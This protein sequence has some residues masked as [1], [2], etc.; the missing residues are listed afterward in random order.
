MIT[1]GEA[2]MSDCTNTGLMAGMNQR[3]AQVESPIQEYQTGF[4]PCT[5]LQ[6]GTFFPELVQ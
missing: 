3:L 5:A 4:C 6:K 1:A 2:C